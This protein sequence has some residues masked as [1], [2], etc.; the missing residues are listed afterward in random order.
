MREEWRAAAR[1]RL[2]RLFAAALIGTVASA[3]AEDAVLVSSTVP[4]YVPGTI[5]T[6]GQRLTLPEGADAVVLFRSGALVRLKGPLDSTLTIDGV[7]GQG[8]GGAASNSVGALV[9][10]LRGGGTD[11]SVIG[12]SRSI[13]M[14]RSAMQG[15][16]LV[17][18][19]Q[20]SAIYCLGPHDNV[21]L[22]RSAGLT[23]ETLRLR[24]GGSVREVGWR[25]AEIE[26]PSDVEIEDGDRFETLAGSGHALATI[27]FR[28]LGET[29]SETA[30]VAES[31]LRGCQEQA[32]PALHEIART[33]A[34][35][36]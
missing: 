26:W 11:A 22:R 8:G 29:S 25:G 5:I 31:L 20:R 9:T 2:I 12:A 16:R 33:L 21:W 7:S 3:H 18:D 6:E 15:Q 13:P 32:S 30:W 34:S 27:I 35:S 19:P 10:A 14:A 23:G 36:H 24:H 28:R 1:W 17:I 4:D